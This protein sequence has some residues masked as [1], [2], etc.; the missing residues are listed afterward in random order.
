M[1]MSGPVVGFPR[2]PNAIF[3]G[4]GIR[5]AR[6]QVDMQTQFAGNGANMK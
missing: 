1:E 5:S 6:Y 3:K 2:L 4:V